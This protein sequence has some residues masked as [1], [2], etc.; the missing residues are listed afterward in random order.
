MLNRDNFYHLQDLKKG[1]FFGKHALIKNESRA[2]TVQGSELFTALYDT[3]QFYTISV[4]FA[5]HCMY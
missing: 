3:T 5:F 1:S 4:V 2:T